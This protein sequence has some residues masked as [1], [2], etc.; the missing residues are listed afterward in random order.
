MNVQVMFTKSLYNFISSLGQI[1][2]PCRLLF[3]RGT[4]AAVSSGKLNFFFIRDLS[5]FLSAFSDFRK[6][7]SNY[8]PFSALYGFRWFRFV[9]YSGLG[10]KRRFYKKYG[11]MFAYIGHR[12]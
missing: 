1:G 5:A 4:R 12:D 8:A 3:D 10:Y 6:L 9:L 2:V 11:V 7:L